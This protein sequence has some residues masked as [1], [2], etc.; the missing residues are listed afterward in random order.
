M[1]LQDYQLYILANTAGAVVA[2]YDQTSWYELR[3]SRMLNAV[4]MCV[5]TVESRDDWL[6]IFALDNFVEV[7]RTNPTTGV[8]EVEDTYLI[9][10]RHTYIDGGVRKITIGAVS[11]NHLLLRRLVDPADDPLQ[12]GGYSTKAGFADAIMAEYAYEQAGAGASVGRPFPNLT[13]QG[14]LNVGNTVGARLRF[15]NLLDVFKDLS[16]RGEVDFLISRSSLAN[17]V[18][19]IRQFGVDRTQTSNEGSGPFVRLDYRRGNMENPSLRLDRQSEANYVYLQGQGQ[20]STRELLEREGQGIADSPYNR[21]EFSA[22]ARNADKGD[23]SALLASADAE[24]FKRQQV[25][26]FDYTAIQGAS[27]ATYKVDFDVADYITIAFDDYRQDVRVIG[28]E[29][30]VNES[31]ESITTFTEIQAVIYD[32]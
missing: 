26:E 32:T 30:T 10:T 17:M 29:L 25:I 7:Q 8:F 14:V 16:V 31:G 12:A 15:D 13:V 2:F 20:G 6:T 19:L 24:L 27:G 22:D 9:R 3:Y 5:F 4:G 23:V 11:L 1:A 18:L 21:I 28:I